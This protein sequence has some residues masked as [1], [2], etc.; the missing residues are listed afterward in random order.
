[1][2]RP[3]TLYHYAARDRR[4]SILRFGLST[5]FDK[6]GFGSIFLTD[7]REKQSVHLDC[8]AVDV[9]GLTAL[10]NDHT[11]EP[12]DGTWWM[13]PG[14]IRPR[15]LR[16][17]SPEEDK[18]VEIQGGSPASHLM[19][20]AA[21]E[22]ADY[23]WR[24]VWPTAFQVEMCGDEATYVEITVLPG[25]KPA[26]YFAWLD[27]DRDELQFIYPSQMEV[28]IASP[29]GFESAVR[30]GEGN[31]VPVWIQRFDIKK[32]DGL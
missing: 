1:M 5:H 27:F 31:I 14:T 19:F 3:T 15:R 23:P 13:Y 28:L 20:A 16:L 24:N 25:E 22:E 29:D 11:T 10:V 18:T 30:R 21:S 17:S 26:C 12:T 2:Q 32:I 8:W 7:T 4:E 6:T 9:S